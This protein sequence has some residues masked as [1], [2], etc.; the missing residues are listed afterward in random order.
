MRSTSRAFTFLVFS[1]VLFGGMSFLAKLASAAMPGA[2][3]AMLR[4]AVGMLPALTVPRL[5]R[6]ALHPGRRDLVLYRGVFGG[7]SVLLLFLSIEHIPVGLATLLNYTSP[8]W[9]G[10]F[11]RVFLG[12]RLDP[13]AIVPLLLAIAGVTLVLWNH[14]GPGEILGIG[15]WELAGLLSALTSGAS[16]TAIRAA[17]RT[18]SSWTIFIT[19]NACGLLATAPFALARWT[20][21]TAHTWALVVAVGLTAMLGQ[22]LMTHAYRWID[23]V[24]AGAVAQLAVVVATGLGVAFLGDHLTPRQMVG[25]ALTIGGVIGVVQLDRRRPGLATAAPAGVAPGAPAAPNPG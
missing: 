23:N 16:V 1:A 17:R 9:S 15:R 12:E 25:A 8:I 11:A 19:F 5:F 22:I 4:F 2:Q 20:P 6:E 13:R 7:I 10:L 3:I 21:A 24:R 14:G 18:E